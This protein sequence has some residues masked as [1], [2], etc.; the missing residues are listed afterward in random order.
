MRASNQTNPCT[1]SGNMPVDGHEDPEEHILAN[2]M[3]LVVTRP[4]YGIRRA[5]SVS[6][7]IQVINVAQK[8]EG[9]RVTGLYSNF[10]QR[11]SL[12]LCSDAFCLP[13]FVCPCLPK[14]RHTALG[15]RDPSA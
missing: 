13:C 10:S 9:I 5:L 14:N 15:I 6:S 4:V 12:C 8:V 2:I 11:V 7:G 3:M 1:Y